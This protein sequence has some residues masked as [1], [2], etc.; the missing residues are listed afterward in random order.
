LQPLGSQNSYRPDLDAGVAD[1]SPARV[2][3]R[4]LRRPARFFRQFSATR[5]IAG[6]PFRIA[7]V[8]ALALPAAGYFVSVN[9]ASNKILSTM[10]S[11]AGF[12]VRQVVV[13]GNQSIDEQALKFQLGT[14]LKKSMLDFDVI[15][16]RALVMQN[17]WVAEATVRKVYPDR[18]VIDIVER[19]PFALWKTGKTVSVIARDGAVIVQAGTDYP[20]LPQVV[21]IGANEFAAELLAAMKRFPMIAGRVEAYVRV[22]GRRWDLLMAGGTRIL[23]PEQEW[24]SALAELYELQARREILDRELVQIDMRLAD[25]LVVRLNPDTAG[26]RRAAIL[27]AIETPGS[28]I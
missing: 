19:Q 26:V 15:A 4:M 17:S 22:A 18:V 5:L 10:A 24:Q 11:S 1:G 8:V 16:A 28:K 13:N 14:G 23:L 21:G 27:K 25:R 9:G 7:L 12:K 6:I 20:V 3:P 2:L